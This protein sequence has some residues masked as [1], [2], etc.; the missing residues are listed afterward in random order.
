MFNLPIAKPYGEIIEVCD[1][2]KRI[3]SC[4]DEELDTSKLKGTGCMFCG[5]GCHLEK[6]PNRFQQMKGNLPK[7]HEYIM[8]PIENNGLGFKEVLD[9]IKVKTE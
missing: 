7:Q 9:F 6:H 1:S 3:D 2:K 4:Y 5:F 8:K